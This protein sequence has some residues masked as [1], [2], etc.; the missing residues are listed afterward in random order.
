MR[1]IL[2]LAASLG[3]GLL[4]LYLAT[5]EQLFDAAL[6]APTDLNIRL[7]AFAACALAALWL[8][9][10]AKLVLLARSQGYRVGWWHALLAHVAQVF[11]TAMSP[12]G[13]GGAPFLVVAL[14]RVG[15]PAGAALALAVQLFVLDLTTLGVLILAG[16]G[17]LT[18][19]A[20]GL[21]SLPLSVT[22][23]VAGL[24]AVAAAALLGRFPRPAVRWLHAIS[25]W[26]LLRRFR[27]RLR[28][29]AS[30]YR[31]SAVAF[32]DL[33]PRTRVSLH[34]A[35]AVAWLA[36]FALF[37]AF[38]AMYGSSARLLEVLALLSMITLLTFFVPTPG[39]A[40]VTEL[41]LGLT[42]GAVGSR[43]TSVAAPVLM[44]RLTT[45]YVAYLVGP[46]C[47]WLLLRHRAPAG[48]AT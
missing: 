45:F 4:G 44:W 37:W 7:V 9:P 34:A 6:Y 27:Y 43:L 41:L 36:N 40:G 20:P 31:A 35:N 30:E 8:A 46:V 10:V 21:L 42:V 24:L 26:R 28:R 25:R 48:D 16:L 14:G 13:A 3:L 32:R 17:Y 29:M 5:R 19:A 11:G 39:A 33:R 18:L 38:L 22:A 12:A 2:L 15:V 23:G 47:G 1:L